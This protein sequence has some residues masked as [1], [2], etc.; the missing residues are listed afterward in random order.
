MPKRSVYGLLCLAALFACPFAHAGTVRNDRSPQ[1]YLDL[2]ADPRYA[3]AGAIHVD[4]SGEASSGSGVLIGDRWV[5]TAAHLLSGT[6]NLTFTVGGAEYDADGWVM[7]PKYTGDLRK[8]FDLGLVRLSEPVTDVTPA[9][10]YRWR[11]EQNRVGVFDGFGRTGTGRTGGQPFDDVDG[12]ARAGTNTID[13][14]VDRKPG[15]GHSTAKL[16]TGANLFVTD[17][18]N[19][20][21]ESDNATGSPTPTDL[22]L[23]ISQGDSGGPVFL[24]APRRRHADDP[25]LVAGI[26]SFGEF[27]DDADD[28][29]YGDITGHTRVAVFRPWIE[30]TMKRATLGKSVPEFVTPEPSEGARELDGMM[31]AVTPEPTTAG[32]ALASMLLCSSRQRR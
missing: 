32:I 21:Y 17:F 19:P 24:D 2:A 1:K 23:L 12:R 11:N 9:G 18:D 4:R 25:P 3:S 15:S 30:R 29:D 14:S 13:G 16:A 5:L 22:E 10:L 6:T 7:H 31:A 20:A 28:S 26:H 8:G 27:V